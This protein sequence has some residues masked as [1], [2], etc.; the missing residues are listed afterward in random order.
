MSE[1]SFRIGRDALIVTTLTV[2]VVASP[3]GQSSATTVSVAPGETLLGIADQYGTTVA[4]LE[5]A[6][7]LADPNTIVAGSVLQVPGR[8]GVMADAPKTTVVVEPGQTISSI[9]A[10]Y[11]TTA[12]ALATTNHLADPNHVVAG[13][14]LQVPG[15][16]AG[17]PAIPAA[18]TGGGTVVVQAGQTLFSIATSFDTTVTALAAANNIV[19]PNNIV[20]GSVLRIPGPGSPARL[21]QVH[22]GPREAASWSQPETR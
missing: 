17:T 14:V 20:I 1:R 16:G 21:R 10:Q 3:F 18:G 13:S 15:A 22:L 6:N 9:A 11:R 7:N 4:A 12:S 2:A 8:S 5:A 19:D